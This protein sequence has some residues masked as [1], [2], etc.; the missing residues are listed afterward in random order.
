VFTGKGAT[1]SRGPQLVELKLTMQENNQ[2][3]EWT[4]RH[5]TSQVL[6]LRSRIVLAC[7][8]CANNI[9]VG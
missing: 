9:A 8:Q 4:R 5:K 3:V 7:A 2:L 6:A 1:M